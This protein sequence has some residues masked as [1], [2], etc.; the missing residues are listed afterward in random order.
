[1][2]VYIS[3]P[4]TGTSDYME[5][6]NEAQKYLESKRYTVINPAVVNSNL[7]K[8]TTWEEYMRVSL[9]LLEQCDAI[10]LL[11]GWERSRGASVENRHAERLGLGV[12]KEI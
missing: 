9:V 4:I 1:M 10:Y 3:G 5:R 7:P 2:K 6:F 8:D 11:K 12:I